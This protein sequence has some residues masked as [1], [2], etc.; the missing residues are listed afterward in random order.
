MR[1]IRTNHLSSSLTPKTF[2]DDVKVRISPDGG[3]IEDLRNLFFLDAAT[4]N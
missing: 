3:S 4:Q 1:I 2:V